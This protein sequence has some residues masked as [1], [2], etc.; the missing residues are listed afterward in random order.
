VQEPAVDLVDA[1]SPDSVATA[2]DA[3]TECQAEACA[4]ECTDAAEELEDSRGLG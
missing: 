1:D 4:Q 3:E 2:S